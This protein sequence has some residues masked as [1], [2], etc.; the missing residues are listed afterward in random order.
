ME[1]MYFREEDR[2]VF[3]ELELAGP[4]DD[5]VHVGHSIDNL[6]MPP[7]ILKAYYADMRD[8]SKGKAKTITSHALGG[9]IFGNG[10][11][12]AHVLAQHGLLGPDI[13]IS[14]A[15]FPKPGDAEL[16]S[17][18]GAH[19]SSTPTTELQ[20]GFP[21]VALQPEHYG[22][23][24][25]GIDC[26]SWGSASI[27]TQMNLLLQYTRCKRS[28]ELAKK[29]LWSRYTGFDVEQVFNLGTVGGAKAVGLEDEIG[30]LKEGMKADL[31]VFEGQSPTMLAAAEEDPVAAIVLHSTARD[32]KMVM[33]NGKI[34][35]S[36]GKIHDMV[37]APR[38]G[39]AKGP[40]T[41]GKMISW[42][43]VALELLQGRKALKDKMA[44]I[45]MKKRGGV[46]DEPISYE[47]E[48]L[49]EEQSF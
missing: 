40:L 19:I 18:F 20:M 3:H 44:K 26:H 31:V 8:P 38:P 29:D 42:R 25:L 45:D 43:D 48:G 34:R 39:E 11:S 17:K 36:E 1:D 13:L 35:K 10:P 14:H 5:R 23:S 47:Q 9:P 16:F 22:H 24:S 37:V 27:P 7:D 12:G 49:I 21:P 33:V 41:V 32:L 4:Y 28:E 2:K 6:Y 15:N 46:Y 30:R